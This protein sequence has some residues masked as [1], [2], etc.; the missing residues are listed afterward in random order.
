MKKDLKEQISRING[1]MRQINESDFSDDKSHYWDK[2][3]EEDDNTKN[4]EDI[5][6]MTGLVRSLVM[7]GKLKESEA[8]EIE[9]ILHT[10]FEHFAEYDSGGSGY[11]SDDQNDRVD[12]WATLKNIRRYI[13]S[14]QD[15]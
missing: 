4:D 6:L 9:N 3:G 2:W 13:R 11:F 14:N 1:M 8:Y 7:D 10:E 15:K 5:E 12:M